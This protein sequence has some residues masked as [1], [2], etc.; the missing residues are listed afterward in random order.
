VEKGCR[1]NHGILTRAQMNNCEGIIARMCLF[2]AQGFPSNEDFVVT[3]AL[4]QAPLRILV[5]GDSFTA[6]YSAD[7]GL[8]WVERLQTAM[9]EGT[10]VWNLAIPATGTNQAVASVQEYAPMMKP[11]LVILGFFVGNDFDDN[12]F[13]LDH[14]RRRISHEE[15]KF[16]RGEFA[17]YYPFVRIYALDD[18]FQ[19]YRLAERQVLLVG[20]GRPLYTTDAIAFLRLSR[21]GTL[22]ANI[23]QRPPAGYHDRFW[24]Y[25]MDRTEHYLRELRDY[26]AATDTP[27]LVLVIPTLAGTK[28]RE[29]PAA[30]AI[31]ARLQIPALYPLDRLKLED[32]LNPNNPYGDRHWNNHGHEV[33]AQMV[34]DCV[35]YMLDYD[36]QPC[37]DA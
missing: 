20:E 27:L 2:N 23:L 1:L 5:A 34:I 19:P 14:Y 31:L 11:D 13:P 6:G 33:G 24:Q 32:Y 16:L 35:R 3:D 30:Q 4:E 36:M 37:P 7:P 22:L 29:Y 15:E 10:H 18:N 28:D 12:L 9:P 26:L 21:T 8:G 17:R 25:S